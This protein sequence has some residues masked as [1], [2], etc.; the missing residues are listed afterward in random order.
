MFSIIC[1]LCQMADEQIYSGWKQNKWLTDVLGV[2]SKVEK[3]HSVFTQCVRKTL[4]ARRD[5]DGQHV[6]CLL[7]ALTATEALS[8]DEIVST[9]VSFIVLG[10]NRVSTASCSALK[11]L[12]K[13]SK[14]QQ[15]IQKEI[16]QHTL[17]RPSSL[18]SFE[19]F[20]LETLRLYPA[21]AYFSKWITE[22]VP[23]NGFFIPPNSSVLVYLRGTALDAQIK[24]P[25][26]FDMDRANP[27]GNFGDEILVNNLPMTLVKGLVGNVVQK[28]QLKEAEVKDA[29][30]T[31]TSSKVLI[32][33]ASL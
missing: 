23:L 19:R 16:M 21:T 13:Q 1:R 6:S 25:E 32:S 20:L 8:P 15:I 17:E 5:V 4:S 11:E 22:G 12:T 18:G 7:D 2:Q 24:N 27:L 10:Y 33:F 9:I 28:Y 26:K 29:I 31:G 30:E 14:S 3:L